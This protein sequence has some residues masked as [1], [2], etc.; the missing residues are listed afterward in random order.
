MSICRIQ[1]SLWHA[2]SVVGGVGVEVGLGSCLT[3]LL[4][5]VSLSSPEALAFQGDKRLLKL[6]GVMSSQVPRTLYPCPLEV[7]EGCHAAQ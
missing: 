3:P 7:E 4:W 1:P 2:S 5:D 6:G